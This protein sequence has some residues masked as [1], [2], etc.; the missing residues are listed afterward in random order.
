MVKVSIKYNKGEIA[1]VGLAQTDI[2]YSI[3]PYDPLNTTVNEIRDF[4]RLP[5]P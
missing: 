1:F 4:L 3:S 5:A 2:P